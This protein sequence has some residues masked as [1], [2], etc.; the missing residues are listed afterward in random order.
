M[1]LTRE[2]LTIAGLSILG[3]ET[4][5]GIPSF[6]ESFEGSK[7]NGN[8]VPAVYLWEGRNSKSLLLFCVVFVIH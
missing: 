1:Q 2:S 7:L 6:F 3:A 4:K 8:A 5:E